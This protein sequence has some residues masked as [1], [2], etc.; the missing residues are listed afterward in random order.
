M[1][2][3][4]SNNLLHE[5]ETLWGR[6]HVASSPKKNL[7]C[8]TAFQQPHLDARFDKD[9][10]TL[11]AENN[12]KW[13]IRKS[14]ADWNQLQSKRCSQQAGGKVQEVA[15][16]RPKALLLR[17]EKAAQPLRVTLRSCGCT[18]NRT[19]SRRAVCAAG[20]SSDQ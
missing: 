9:S 13:F 18:S 14:G 2:S 15:P 19:A 8:T 3:R 6:T 10:Q 5:T 1:G 12:A 11:N 7:S 4:S 17:A 20:L 16:P